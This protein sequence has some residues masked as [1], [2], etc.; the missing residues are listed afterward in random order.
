D[1]AMNLRV[2]IELG[3]ERQQISVRSGLRQKVRDR[4]DGET[5]ADGLLHAHV[6]LQSWIIADPHESQARLHTALLQKRNALGSPGVNLF[7][8]GTPVNEIGHRHQGTT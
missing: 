6:N 1:N 5:R 8:N 3:Y 7:G 4:S 2:S